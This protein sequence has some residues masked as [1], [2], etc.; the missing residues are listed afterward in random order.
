VLRGVGEGCIE[1][2]DRPLTV[3]H[4]VRQCQRQERKQPSGRAN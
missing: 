4:D 1:A 2:R 3:A